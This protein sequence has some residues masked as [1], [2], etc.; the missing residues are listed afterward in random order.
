MTIRGLLEE[1]AARHPDRMALTWC[2]D[3]VW[4]TRTWREWLARVRDFAEGYG[5][6]FGLVPG[7]DNTAIVLGNSPAWLE[8]YLAQA[9]A[10]VAVVPI[11][12]K[13][14]E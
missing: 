14:H 10:G 9:G 3:K 12:P 2:E 13:L 5:T 4:K 7:K 6:R 11:D 8:S 1:N